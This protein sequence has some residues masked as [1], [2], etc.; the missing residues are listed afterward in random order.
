MND[1]NIDELFDRRLDFPDPDA[2]RRFSRLVGIDEAKRRLIRSLAL[3]INPAALREWAKKYHPSSTALIDLVERRPPL[4][5]LAGDVGT[6]KTELATTVGDPV[7]RQ[8]NITITLFPL[9]LSTR[10]SGRVGEM[11][12]LLSDAFNETFSAASRLMVRGSKSRGAVILFVDEGDSLAQ[13]RENSQMHHEDRAGVNAFIRGIDRLAERHLPAAVILA[14]N[15]LSAIDP[16]VQ[17]RAA[18]I[19]HFD[20]PTSEQ[21]LAVLSTS[22]KEIGF[23]QK[24][25]E[26]IVKRTGASGDG[27]AGFTYSDLTQRLLPALVL[28]AYPDG[29]ITFRRALE[30]LATIR[31]TTRFEE[32]HMT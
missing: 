20:R 22:L 11:T 8:E 25:I 17:R 2:S 13:S 21:R 18:E 5:I 26:E 27:Q 31:P 28:D 16:A 19:F 24:E 32:L 30:V 12:K 15:R 14:T 29:G 10:G 9:S 4:L 6:G 23:S 7:A 1:T 3:A